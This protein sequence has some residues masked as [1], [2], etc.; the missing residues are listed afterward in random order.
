MFTVPLTVTVPAFAKNSDELAAIFVPL[1][2]ILY[3][4]L[5]ELDALSIVVASATVAD[6]VVD[7]FTALFKAALFIAATFTASSDILNTTAFVN[8]PIVFA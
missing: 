4:L 5:P 8:P 2:S 1:S 6:V 3:V 7:I